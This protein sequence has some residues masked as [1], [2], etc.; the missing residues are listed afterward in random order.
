MIKDRSQ[1]RVRIISV[2]V[3]EHGSNSAIYMND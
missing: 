2:E 1:D 3:R